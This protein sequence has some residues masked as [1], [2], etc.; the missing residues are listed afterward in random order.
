MSLFIGS[1]AF[2]DA[3][4]AEGL[5]L[6]VFAGSVLSGVCGFLLLRALLA[7]RPARGAP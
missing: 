4:H 2:G 3:I 1:L 7:R 6:G 5:R